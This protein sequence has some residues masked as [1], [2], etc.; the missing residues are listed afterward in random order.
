MQSFW[1]IIH[2]AFFLPDWF[3]AHSNVL[4]GLNTLYEQLWFQSNLENPGLWGLCYSAW[5]WWM[6]FVNGCTSQQPELQKLSPSAKRSL[7]NMGLNMSLLY[8][9]TGWA[10][11][12]TLCKSHN[13]VQFYTS[14]ETPD[15]KS[16]EL[17]SIAKRKPQEKPQKQTIK[18]EQR[19]MPGFWQVSTFC[20]ITV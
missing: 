11:L 2:F 5:D 6:L 19:K 20:P 7:Q 8:S 10:S 17:W 13:M 9:P 12:A 18:K 14:N 15:N 3:I 16:Q 4:K 1:G